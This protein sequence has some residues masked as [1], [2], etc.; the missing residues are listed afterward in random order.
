MKIAVGTTNR[1]KLEAVRQGFEKSVSN[2]EIVGHPIASGIADQPMGLEETLKG[3]TNRAEGAL[4]A[5]KNADL[6]V[7][8]EAGLIRVEDHLVDIGCVCILERSGIRGYALS[9]GFFIPREVKE[10]IE[11]GK[12]M[13]IAVSEAYDKDTVNERDCS[14][15]ITDGALPA[16]LLYRQAVELAFIDYGQRRAASG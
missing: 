3:A 9:Q 10:L 2:A 4:K 15:V 5:D 14:G 8:L 11:S 7:G 6:G 1:L 16:I 13:A 12:E